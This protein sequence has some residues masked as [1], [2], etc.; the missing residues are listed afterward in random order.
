MEDGAILQEISQPEPYLE[1]PMLPYPDCEG[2]SV[3][4]DGRS[5]W[6]GGCWH[7]AASASLARR[8]EA[9]L[10]GQTLD[11]A[12][13]LEG[14]GSHEACK[15][16]VWMFEVAD[17]GGGSWRLLFFSLPKLSRY[18]L[19]SSQCAVRNFRTVGLRRT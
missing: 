14:R 6:A 13:R 15:H 12:R 18:D 7:R 5:S 17:D 3:V 16:L 10:L 9:C 4:G 1:L 11:A 19:R 8:H 2:R